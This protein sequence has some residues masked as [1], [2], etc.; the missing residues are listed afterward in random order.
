MVLSCE[1]NSDGAYDIITRTHGN[2]KDIVPRNSSL[3]MITIV[4]SA[5]QLIAV[6]CYDGILKTIPIN[7]DNKT[8]NTSTL[9]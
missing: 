8:L 6:K 4:D 5:K 7:S 1:H 2:I 9:R 3:Q